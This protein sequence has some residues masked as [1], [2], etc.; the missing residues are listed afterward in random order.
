MA[1]TN[2]VVALLRGPEVQSINFGAEGVKINGHVYNTLATKIE[3]G[4][5]HV[6]VDAAALGGGTDGQYT[7]STNTL[8]LPWNSF[9]TAYSKQ[10][11]VH[12]LTHAAIDDMHL[13]NSRGLHKTEGEG[14]S[15]IAE[16]LYVRF[17][18]G[19]PP[20]PTD[21]RINRVADA[22]AKK[23]VAAGAHLYTVS[24]AEMQRLRNAIGQH[25]VYRSRRGHLVNSDGI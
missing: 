2:D 12:E 17:L 14:I 8:T 4:L 11:V 7:S 23:I 18:G 3:S 19:T 1:I 20:G 6:T 25:P 10:V 9:P 24:P 13:P 5:L 16:Q 21:W 22:I 15:Y